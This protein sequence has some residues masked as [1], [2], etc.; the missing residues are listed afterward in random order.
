MARALTLREVADELGASYSGVWNL[1]RRG[2]LPAFR[3]GVGPKGR[4]RV[5]VTALEAFIRTRSTATEVPSGPVRPR[6]GRVDDGAESMF[7]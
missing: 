2:E 5:S 6:G 7:R 1:I 3:L 4:Y